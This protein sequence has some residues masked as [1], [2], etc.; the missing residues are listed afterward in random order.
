MIYNA[1]AAYFV[2]QLQFR[3]LPFWRTDYEDEG[4]HVEWLQTLS[5]KY[6]KGTLY[7]SPWYID[8]PR[9]TQPKRNLALRISR[10]RHY[11]IS[12]THAGI[13]SSQR[14]CRALACSPVTPCFALK[15]GRI[16]SYLFQPSLDIVFLNN[17][18]YRSVLNRPS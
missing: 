12:P 2:Q 17:Q 9:L 4:I 7:A 13:S 1:Y 11:H 15:Y 8:S 10:Q 18:G 14:G 6:S 16:R 5:I 3:G